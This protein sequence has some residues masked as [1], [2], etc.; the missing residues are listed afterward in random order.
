MA[1]G[2]H[3]HEALL[4]TRWMRDFSTR[5]PALT[6]LVTPGDDRDAEQ[7]AFDRA[8]VERNTSR[9]LEPDQL[10]KTEVAREEPRVPPGEPRLERVAERGIERCELLLVGEAHAVGWIR[11]QHAARRGRTSR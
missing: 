1:G 7:P 9:D 3:R 5:A 2:K 11:E 4:G 10:R 6:A 8:V